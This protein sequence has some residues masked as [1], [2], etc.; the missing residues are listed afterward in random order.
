VGT[1]S[2]KMTNKNEKAWG[3]GGAIRIPGERGSISSA[4]GGWAKDVV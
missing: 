3:G 1:D 2:E 4:K